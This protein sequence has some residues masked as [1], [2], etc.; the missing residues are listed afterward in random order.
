METERKPISLKKPRN[1]VTDFQ[2]FADEY[3]HLNSFE[4]N[5]DF[6]ASSY[7]TSF[8]IICS[9]CE[10]NSQNNYENALVSKIRVKINNI[11]KNKFEHFNS[12][13]VSKFLINS[14]IIFL[15]LYLVPK[16]HRPDESTAFLHVILSLVISA[17][18]WLFIFIRP[19]GVDKKSMSKLRILSLAQFLM[20]TVLTVLASMLY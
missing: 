9:P 10:D 20:A 16:I 4:E 5:L 7:S 3:R 19:E 14:N 1:S 2:T 15:L 6:K 8:P 13:I 17:L 12:G 11:I 18:S